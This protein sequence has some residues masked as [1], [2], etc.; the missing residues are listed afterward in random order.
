MK[1][2]RLES[3]QR[4]NAML[5]NRRGG[6]A[7]S[8]RTWSKRKRTKYRFGPG[9]QAYWRQKRTKPRQ[10]P[11]DEGAAGQFVFQC[12]MI[13]DAAP[14]PDHFTISIDLKAQVLSPIKSG[15][16]LQQHLQPA[17]ILHLVFALHAVPQGTTMFA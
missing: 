15:A 2:N 14:C 12:W 10:R 1:P 4:I 8:G 6:K 7:R 11:N 16:G 5:D 17:G 3:R 13:L 9:Y